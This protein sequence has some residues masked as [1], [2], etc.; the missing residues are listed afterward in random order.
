MKTHQKDMNKMSLKT[1]VENDPLVLN[2]D[3]EQSLELVQSDLKLAIEA[4]K[5]I[6]IWSEDLEQ[7]KG[8]AKYI[9]SKLEH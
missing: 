8:I 2:S 4:L 7:A 6:L 1:D 9:L 5:D 3:I